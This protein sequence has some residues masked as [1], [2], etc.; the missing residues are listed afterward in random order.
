MLLAN[1]PFT[2]TTI[3]LAHSVC[4]LISIGI[5]SL[6]ALIVL[7]TF[8][9]RCWPRI[10]VDPRTP[11][12]AMWY[13]ANSAL[14]RG[15]EGAAVLDPRLREGRIRAIG[16]RYW[17]GEGPGGRVGV[18]SDPGAVVYGDKLA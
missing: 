2:L 6:M 3:W 1:V 13:V 7:C 5:L 12:G 4:A 9:I 8:L 14:I 15:L 16:G 18:Y 11:A 17:F 10:P